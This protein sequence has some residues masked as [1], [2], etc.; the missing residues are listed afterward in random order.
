MIPFIIQITTPEETPGK[1]VLAPVRRYPLFM[2]RKRMKEIVLKS[3]IAILL[4]MLF[5]TLLA[6]RLFHPR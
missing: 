3:L 5:V 1:W 4:A 2:K 6:Q